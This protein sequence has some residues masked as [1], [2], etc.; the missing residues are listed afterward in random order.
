MKRLALWIPLLAVCGLGVLALDRQVASEPERRERP[1]P[2]GLLEEERNT[3]QIFRRVA[4]SV[5]YITSIDR[6]RSLFSLNVIE[7]RRGSGSGFIWDGDGHVVT[8][9]HVVQGG[10][11]FSITL[12]DGTSHPAKLV[13]IAPNKDLAVLRI[14]GLGHEAPPL[15]TGNSQDLVVGQKVLAVGNPF[16]LDQTLT[17]GVISALG[18]EIPSATG[19]TIR[20]VIQTDASINPGNSGGPLLDSSGRLIGVNTAIYSP[21]GSSAGIGFA[22]PAQTVERIIP[23]L[24]RYGVVKRVGLGI[25]ILPDHVARR[26]RV[27][28]VIVRE[29]EPGGAADKAGIRSL[30]LDR[31]GN[32]RRIDVL[33]EIDGVGLERY[34]D[35]YTALDGHKAGDEVTVRFLRGHEH[36]EVLVR[37]QPIN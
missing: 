25:S 6:R 18:R 17:T 19:T 31:Y 34:D 16:G 33:V 29:V 26:L 22:V 13:G 24:I 9:F 2:A 27:A 3:I 15:P 10:D 36:H 32:V 12:A 7:V 8:N 28:G 35:L 30:Q 23:Q 20:D 14:E 1:L 4:G 37:L 5:V 21:T 11:S